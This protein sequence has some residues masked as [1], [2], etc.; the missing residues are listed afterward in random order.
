MITEAEAKTKWCPFSRYKFAGTSDNPAHNREGGPDGHWNK[1]VT[2]GTRCLGSACMAWR[3]GEPSE[4]LSAKQRASD[5]T[6]APR[7]DGD[8]WQPVRYEFWSSPQNRPSSHI[9]HWKREV[10][11]GF[12]GLAG[13]PS[14]PKTGA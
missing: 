14:T 2:E 5:E 7:P 3:A 11:N 4:E 1:Y 8:G 6:S 13:S 10:P 12:C 9:N